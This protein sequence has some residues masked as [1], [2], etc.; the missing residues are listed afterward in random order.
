M[1]GGKP[2][3][4]LIST[5]AFVGIGP[6]ITNAKSI[7]PKNNFFISKLLSM[8]LRICLVKPRSINTLPEDLTI[9]FIILPS[10]YECN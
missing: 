7:V 10:V 8:F 5:S 1:G 3:L 2:I 9:G 4:T 6:A